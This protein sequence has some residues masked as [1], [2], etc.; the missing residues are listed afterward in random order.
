MLIIFNEHIITIFL[1]QVKSNNNIN[2]S[3]PNCE[4]CEI[5]ANH[6]N[7]QNCIATSGDATG[8]LEKLTTILQV[9][10]KNE[11][12]L[13]E[14]LHLIRNL[15]HILY[16]LDNVDA[17]N[18]L[19]G[20]KPSPAA[21]NDYNDKPLDLSVKSN[22]GDKDIASLRKNAIAKSIAIKD[23][24]DKY[25]KPVKLKPK[26]LNDIQIMSKKGPMKAMPLS[27]C[28]KPKGILYNQCSI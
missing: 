4:T 24:T 17:K 6:I 25:V 26:K 13:C 9:K 5:F 8:T 27:N 1:Q 20:S 14:G 28:I 18:K 2:L 19:N 12:Q 22:F 7:T 10:N 16:E 15:L 3:E 23:E 11:E 21:K